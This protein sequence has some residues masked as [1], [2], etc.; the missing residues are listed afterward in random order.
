MASSLKEGLL[1]T[2]HL[3]RDEIRRSIAANLDKRI[4]LEELDFIPKHEHGGLIRIQLCLT[5]WRIYLVT[6]IKCLS[7]LSAYF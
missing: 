4:K 6:I 2:S 5:F 7:P 1:A 3:E